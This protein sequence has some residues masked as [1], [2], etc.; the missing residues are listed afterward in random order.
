MPVSKIVDMYRRK[1]GV[2]VGPAFGRS[3]EIALYR[4]RRTG[5]LFWRPEDIAGD[6]AFYIALSAA[7][8]NYYQTDRWEYARARRY[9]EGKNSALEIGC[10]RGY[11]LRSIEGIVPHALGIELNSD[12][13]RD[14]VTKFPVMRA[15]I[16]ELAMARAGEFQVVHA[17]QV[18]EHIADPFRF[19]ESALR[20]V[21]DGGLVI[22]STP[23]HDYETFRRQQDAFDLPPHH[24]GHFD[25][26][27]YE[28]IA[29]V[30]G[31]E[32]VEIAAQQAQPTGIVRALIDSFRPAR[33]AIGPTMMA[34]Y[35]K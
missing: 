3:S 14:K 34:V 23:N 17:F 6:E 20:C 28:S 27:I 22:L 7:W 33:G 8:A 31:L 18:L 32:V 9:L 1:C 13:I 2:D 35:R 11:Y 21:A 10:G 4:C 5:Y 24:M 29:A 15:S 25:A 19:L 30:F 16:D 26:S 12:A